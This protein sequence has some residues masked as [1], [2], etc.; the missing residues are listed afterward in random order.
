VKLYISTI[1]ILIYAFVTFGQSEKSAVYT[2]A[3]SNARFEVIKS[4]TVAS[5]TFR[6]DRF[7]GDVWILSFSNDGDLRW[8]GMKIQEFKPNQ[9]L[10]PTFQI[11]LADKDVRQ[12]FLMNTD[13]GQTWVLAD[14]T[15]EKTGEKFL[16]WASFAK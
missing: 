13:T 11:F 1:L 3:N 8:T 16:M 9:T 7:T 14:T 4:P 10:K 15:V 2:A 6:L 12:T 5:W